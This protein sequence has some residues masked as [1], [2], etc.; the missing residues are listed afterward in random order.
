[1]KS[2]ILQ[3]GSLRIKRDVINRK[4]KLKLQIKRER[5]RR[6]NEKRPCWQ[7]RQITELIQLQIYNSIT[8]PTYLLI[9]EVHPARNYVTRTFLA[10]CNP[11]FQSLFL[12]LLRKE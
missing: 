2:R 10:K 9:V 3:L 4:T 8:K 1:M 7:K 12:S 11:S 6:V 5:G